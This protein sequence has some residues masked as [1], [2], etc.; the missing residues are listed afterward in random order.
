MPE[1]PDR[2]PMQ[3]AEPF[4]PSE[5]AVPGDPLPAVSRK[6]AR[7]TTLAAAAGL[8]A[9]IILGTSGTL[10]VGS[11]AGGKASAAATPTEAAAAAVAAPTKV[12]KDAVSTCHLEKNPDAMLGDNDTSL[13]I[14]GAGDKD[15]ATLN[16]LPESLVNCLLDATK[17]PDYVRAQ[18]GKTRALDGTQHGTWRNISASWTYHPDDGLDVVMTE[19]PTTK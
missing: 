3:P 17:T 5:G 19:S 11:V 2:A 10:V 13:T 1:L 6:P 8:V 14:N 16:G 9:G 4:S 15:F 18:M 12:L 7:K